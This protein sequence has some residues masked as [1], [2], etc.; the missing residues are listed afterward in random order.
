MG[1]VVLDFT[2]SGSRKVIAR[3]CVHSWPCAAEESKQCE[4]IY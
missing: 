4:T 3:R 1:M 2:E